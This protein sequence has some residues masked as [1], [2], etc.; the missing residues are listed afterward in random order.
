MSQEIA[1]T[2]CSLSLRWR[3][4]AKV[5][6][7]RSDN[8]RNINYITQLKGVTHWIC[9]NMFGAFFEIHLLGVINMKNYKHILLATDFS[10]YSETAAKR[11]AELASRY[12]A[13]LTLLHVFSHYPQD[14]PNDWIAHEDVAPT[15]YLTKRAEEALADLAA[16]LE[17][18]DI[19][20]KVVISTSSTKHEIVD[21]AREHNVDLI[22]M[23]SHGRHGLSA[24]LGTVTNG[25]L[26]SAPCDVLVVRM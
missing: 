6:Q 25:I 23:G 8:G 2:W 1:L 5:W 17:L 26:H 20:R 19:S 15:K 16:Q 7:R 14:I 11:A 21:F 13:K 22:V 18:K 10:E 12:K 9:V 3:S 24:I 4:S